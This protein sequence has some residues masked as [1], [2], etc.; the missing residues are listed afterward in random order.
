MSKERLEQII[1][2]IYDD[3]KSF[4]LES[5]KKVIKL[6]TLAGEE[7]GNYFISKGFIKQVNGD[8]NYYYDQ[9]TKVGIKIELPHYIDLNTTYGSIR[10]TNC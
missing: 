4:Q 3:Y 7:V 5:E 1:N 9:K 10:L 2:K 8:N 6:L